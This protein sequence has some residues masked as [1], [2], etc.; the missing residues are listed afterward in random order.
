MT[1]MTYQDNILEQPAALKRTLAGLG[2]GAHLAAL[3]Q[4]VRSGAFKRIIL[5]GMGSSFHCF[6]PLYYPLLRAGAPVLMLEAAELLYYAPG[7]LAPGNLVIAAS[8]SGETV[9]IARL[10]EMNQ[11]KATLLGISNAAGSTLARNANALV[12]TAAGEESGVSSK[13]YLA[14]QLA[15]A[16]LRT[17]LLG[18]DVAA[19][20]AELAQAPAAISAYHRELEQHVAWLAEQLGQVRSI[21]YTGRGPSLAAVLT[22][23]LTTKE[24]TWFAAEGLSSA[25]F[26]HG[27][28]EMIDDQRAVLVFAGEADTAALNH[29]LAQEA[30][31]TGARV[32]YVSES[33]EAAA[34]RLPACTP[35][36]R[37]IYEMLPVQ[38]V[39]LALAQLSAH[40]AGEFRRV[41]K[42][43]SV[44]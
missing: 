10:L 41:T 15:L 4:Q 42:V 20:K 18:G 44:E 28:I 16:W 3:A 34:L 25:A 11:G 39:T 38:M 6:Y 17:V 14:M 35:A 33:S 12:L 26:R 21:F 1:T 9:E 27:P 22:A 37:P 2:D 30:A 5:T 29:K 36:T 43:T 40:K 32:L 24:S 13:T 19:V 8:Q 31:E 7:L 23:G